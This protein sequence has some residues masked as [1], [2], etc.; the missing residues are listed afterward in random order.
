MAAFR[1]GG[2]SAS[3]LRQVFRL[4]DSDNSRVL[5]AQELRDGLTRYG[6]LDAS[7]TAALS[8][9][10]GQLDKSRSN[11]ISEDEF[12][13]AFTKSTGGLGAMLGQDRR[14]GGYGKGGAAAVGGAG[15]GSTEA[16]TRIRVVCWSLRGVAGRSYRCAEGTLPADQLKAFVAAHVDSSQARQAD[17][18]VWIDVAGFST[19]AVAAVAAIA[20]VDRQTVE[21]A[22]LPQSQRLW[23]MPPPAPGGPGGS[24][25]MRRHS[26]GGGMGVSAGGLPGGAAGGAASPSSQFDHDFGLRFYGSLPAAVPA[27]SSTARAAR[28]SMAQQLQGANGLLQAQ[29]LQHQRTARGSLAPVVVAVVSDDDGSSPPPVS[30]PAADAAAAAAAAATEAA[31]AEALAADGFSVGSSSV[32][33][34]TRPGSG[35]R[36]AS[37]TG[38]AAPPPLLHMPSAGD[39]LSAVEVMGTARRGSAAAMAATGLSTLSPGGDAGPAASGGHVPE[40]EMIR[41]MMVLHATILLHSGLVEGRGVRRRLLCGGGSG[42]ASNLHVCG[43]NL[44]CGCGGADDDADPAEAEHRRLALRTALAVSKTAFGMRVDDDDEDEDELLHDDDEDDDLYAAAA[45]GD[46]APAAGTASSHLRG[47]SDG[48]VNPTFSAG[49]R[50]DVG[51]SSTSARSGLTASAS[52]SA[53]GGAGSGNPSFGGVGGMSSGAGSVGGTTSPRGVTAY[54]GAS[55]R[56][57]APAPDDSAAGGSAAVGLQERTR[58]S[59]GNVVGVRERTGSSAAAMGLHSSGSATDVLAAAA[60]GTGGSHSSA[61]VPGAGAGAGAGGSPTKLRTMTRRG[62][63]STVDDDEDDGAGAGS[64]AARAAGALCFCCKSDASSPPPASLASSRAL[65]LRP[66]NVVN[67]QFACF[68]VSDSL[69]ITVRPATPLGADDE[70]GGP[71]GSSLSLGGAAPGAG[72]GGAFSARHRQAHRRQQC[73]LDVLFRALRR[74]L[75]AARPSGL[76]AHMSLYTSGV[77][78]LAVELLDMTLRFNAGVRD[79]L[80]DW[81]ARLGADIEDFF[82]PAHTK[83]ITELRRAAGNYLKDMLPVS[84]ALKRAVELQPHAS[85]AAA[86]AGKP[87]RERTGAA[88]RAAR[89]SMVGGLASPYPAMASPMP[90]MQGGGGGAGAAGAGQAVGFGAGAAYG[91]SFGAPSIMQQQQQQPPAGAYGLGFGGAAGMSTGLPLPPGTSE[92]DFRLAQIF[93]PH[94]HAVAEISSGLGLLLEDV[95]RIEGTCNDLI[96]QRSSLQADSMNKVMLFL[97]ITTTLGLVPT[98][99]RCVHTE[100]VQ[101]CSDRSFMLQQAIIAATLVGGCRARGLPL[102]VPLFRC[103][104]QPPPALYSGYYGQNFPGMFSEEDPGIGVG[105]FWIAVLIGTVLMILL[106]WRLGFFR[107]IG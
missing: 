12:V 82:A 101:Q 10:M 97:S 25:S 70:H 26:G 67:D 73:A 79:A 72:K 49:S 36:S 46:P 18:R 94:A 104:L 91:S 103:L 43:V 34:V 78:A 3:E 62:S 7:D 52:A 93:L 65:R 55:A 23:P 21:D 1:D 89:S 30:P 8:R 95:S 5:T 54:L 61:G 50:D 83:H 39:M 29:Q 75:R 44:G 35:V 69:I 105:S 77:R 68:V 45:D 86:A 48:T 22:C 13:A 24:Q 2:L 64:C 80:S 106:I 66:P 57:V 4:L 37:V 63:G 28:L 58:S 98:V 84:D 99:I 27:G 102:P 17:Q 38:S 76:P 87:V 6:L 92:V 42:A 41:L 51:A 53:G 85:A 33:P 19:D 32:M 71:S 20:R 14:F 74:G 90:T 9:L 59:A 16:P 81:E 100:A 96:A 56:R 47:L 88:K 40:Q 60:T 11:D 107:L 31:A 15:A